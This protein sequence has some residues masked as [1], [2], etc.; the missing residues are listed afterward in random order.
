MLRRLILWK[1]TKT[2]YLTAL[3]LSFVLMMVQIF[4][5]GSILFGLPLSSS[6]PFFF[7][8]FVY[9]V[10]FFLPDGVLVAT[11]LTLY[12]L[13][14]KRLLQ[15][16]YSFHI[17]PAKVLL[18]FSLPAA[19]F[20]LL[21][22]VLSFFLFE[23][24]V[25]FARRWLL[26]NYRDRIFENIPERTFMDTG[27]IVVCVDRK[28]GKELSNVFLRYRNTHVLAERASYEGKGRFLFEGGSLLTK[29][30]DKYF[31]MEFKRY[32]LDTEE[33]FSTSIR[34]RK[35]R[36]EREERTLNL[37]NSLSLVPLF[38]FSFFG[39]LRLCRTHTQVYY[40]IAAGIV[41]HQLALFALKVSL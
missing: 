18:F 12:E 3:L 9:Y 29:E 36:E 20:F 37:A 35:K 17:S 6:L 28:E 2:A 26:L 31:L 24:N 14:E 27:G 38:L 1:V 4:R 39:V 5:I 23:E 7:V 30:R 33:L 25:S 21:S 19:F 34:E 11:A 32:W 41:L 40:L 15:V 10:F 16:M 13:K 22:L 8:W